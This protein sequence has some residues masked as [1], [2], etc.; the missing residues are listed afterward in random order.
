MGHVKKVAN[1]IQSLDIPEGQIRISAAHLVTSISYKG[2]PVESLAMLS[3]SALRNNKIR[4]DSLGGAIALTK[5]G[6]EFARSHFN[7]VS[8]FKSKHDKTFNARFVVPNANRARWAI[9]WFSDIERGEEFGLRYFETSPTRELISELCTSELK[10]YAPVVSPEDEDWARSE[11]KYLGVSIQP[12]PKDGVG[13]SEMSVQ[14]P[15][16]RVFHGWQMIVPKRLYDLITT[17]P[18][19][20]LLD[21]DSHSSTLGGSR[22]G[23]LPGGSILGDNVG[24]EFIL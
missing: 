4:Y 16:R 6:R 15:T 1:K 22:W 12:P 17:A 10:G 9:K 3:V 24:L 20:V 5:L 7:G 2:G 19:I 18:Q 13:T 11:L 23:M 21:I 14:F 8:F